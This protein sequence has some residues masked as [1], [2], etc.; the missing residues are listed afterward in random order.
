MEAART[1]RKS[2]KGAAHKALRRDCVFG[3][4]RLSAAAKRRLEGA[5]EKLVED[6]V[7]TAKR[8]AR[9]E[10]ECARGT[11]TAGAEDGVFVSRRH[12]QLASRVIG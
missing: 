6:I 11:P 1:I 7:C 9:F 10:R 5:A 12:M 3:G 4:T 2:V 8:I